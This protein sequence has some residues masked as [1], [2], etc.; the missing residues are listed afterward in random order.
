M[1]SL[2]DPKLELFARFVAE[3]KS[4]KEAAI[5]AGYS[6]KSAG[7]IG[8]RLAKKENISA[9]IAELQEVAAQLSIQK[10]VLSKD[11]VLEKLKEN[12]ERALQ[13]IPVLDSQGQATGEY[14]YEGNVANKALELLGKHVGLFEGK[15][16]E[17]AKPN[18]IE[19]KWV[20]PEPEPKDESVPSAASDKQQKPGARLQC[21]CSRR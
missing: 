11:W 19:Y 14:R 1:P 21:V 3:G 10:L 17:E 9:R 18:K 2:K 12:V 16:T 13:A 6:E 8:S 4:H 20:M 5:A 15:Q 7:Q